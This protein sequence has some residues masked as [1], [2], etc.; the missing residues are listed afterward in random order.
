MAISGSYD[1]TVTRDDIIQEAMERCGVLRLNKTATSD[2]LASFARSL[3]LKV[4]ALQ[5][6]G[7][8]LHTWREAFMFLEYGEDIYTLGPTGDNATES[9]V[10]TTLSTDE[11]ASSTSI[12]LTSITGISAS[13]KI[14][15]ELDDGTLHWDVV[16]GAPG[17][18]VA[19][20]TTGLAS[21]ATAGNVVFAYTTKIQRPLKI[22]DLFLRN[23]SSEDTPV[24]L[25]SITRYRGMTSKTLS[26]GSMSLAS[27]DP[28][29]T[30]GV[31][32]VWPVADDVTEVLGFM[33]KKP[34]DDLDS[35]SNNAAYPA[36]WNEY[37]V[38]SLVPIIADKMSLPLSERA[39][40]V[41]KADKARMDL[42]DIE[43]VSVFIRPRS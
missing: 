2:Q 27:Y 22:S 32:R 14:G 8:Q 7:L 18:G 35:A 40:H 28:Q 13:D 21:A 6:D 17:A 39:Y 31:L 11:A 38:T 9:Y 5:A 42:F 20:L 15:V 16:N 37:L 23:T 29:L 30:N 1:F 12:G 33:Y 43:G 34:V 10:R 19:T 41:A 25:E 36:D 4:K 26:Y 24:G 3:N